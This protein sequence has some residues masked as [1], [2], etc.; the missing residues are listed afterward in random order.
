MEAGSLK[1]GHWDALKNELPL[2]VVARDSLES[3]VK[4]ALIET[5]FT[6]KEIKA[7]LFGPKAHSETQ[8][9]NDVLLQL[10]CFRTRTLGFE[11]KCPSPLDCS[12]EPAEK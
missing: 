7:C 1:F 8:C 12:L 2:D 4:L 5:H 3:L 10:A 9:D 6:K 11:S